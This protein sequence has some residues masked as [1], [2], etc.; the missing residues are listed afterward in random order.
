[1]GLGNWPSA[2]FRPRRLLLMHVRNQATREGHAH[3][4]SYF[5][6]VRVNEL[7]EPFAFQLEH[8]F[9]V[10]WNMQQASRSLAE[11]SRTALRATLIASCEFACTPASDGGTACP[12]RKSWKRE[13]LAK[14][15]FRNALSAIA[16]KKPGFKVKRNDRV[17]V[18]IATRKRASGRSST[19]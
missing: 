8:R 9:R 18:N 3:G 6:E 2:W 12:S 16:E 1:L 17:V 7:A 11:P 4:G 13:S 5:C 15:K 14:S 10:R 19:R